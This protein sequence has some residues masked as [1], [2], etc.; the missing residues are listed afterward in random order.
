ML[1]VHHVLLLINQLIK[2]PAPAKL[3]SCAAIFDD[4]SR[5]CNDFVPGPV[6]IVTINYNRKR[7]EMDNMPKLEL[8]NI[9]E[10]VEN[11]PVNANIIPF[12]DELV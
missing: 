4:D 2:A 9:D 5:C 10:A 7:N 3:A 6:N 11:V 12:N 8:I 1:F